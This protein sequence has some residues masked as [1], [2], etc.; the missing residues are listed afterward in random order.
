MN[1]ISLKKRPR[2]YVTYR[3][4]FVSRSFTAMAHTASATTTQ[5]LQGTAIALPTATKKRSLNFLAAT[6]STRAVLAVVLHR[7]AV[8]SFQSHVVP[9]YF[10]MWLF[11]ITWL[12]RLKI[13]SRLAS[14]WFTIA[15][16]Y[17]I[18]PT[19]EPTLGSCRLELARWVLSS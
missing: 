7:E 8:F 15:L 10:V 2:C 14:N 16:A 1:H 6:C 18:S 19:V 17:P 5:H 9:P 4:A 13:K 3:W 12:A 11:G